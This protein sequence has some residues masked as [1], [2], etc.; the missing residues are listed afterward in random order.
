[1]KKKEFGVIVKYDKDRAYGFI[2]PSNYFNSYSGV[3]FHIS[4]FDKDVV[5]KVDDKVSYVV[6]QTHKGDKAINIKI[7][8]KGYDKAREEAE[9]KRQQELQRRLDAFRASYSE[10]VDRLNVVAQNAIKRHSS[11]L[12]LN[13]SGG[14]DCLLEKQERLGLAIT[15]IGSIDASDEF[16]E[17]ADFELFPTLGVKENEYGEYTMRPDACEE[18]MDKLKGVLNEIDD[19]IAPFK[20][21]IEKKKERE[22]REP[23]KNEIAKLLSGRNPSE[24][25]KQEFKQFVRFITKL[26]DRCWSD[27]MEGRSL[28]VLGTII[29]VGTHNTGYFQPSG[30]RNRRGAMRY[31]YVGEKFKVSGGK[32][33]SIARWVS[34]KRNWCSDLQHYRI[35]GSIDDSF[36]EIIKELKKIEL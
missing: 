36:D 24:L 28:A 13:T 15:D 14:Y 19:A 33:F 11:L 1:M 32:C 27:D 2:K 17:K 22:R 3:F 18:M 6:I 8:E 35:Q 10:E 20:A 4:G 5:P 7:D 21:E 9:E 34:K 23:I 29:A 16:W 25:D 12:E 31:A 30:G 26:E